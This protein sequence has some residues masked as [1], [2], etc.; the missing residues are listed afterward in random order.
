MK[1]AIYVRVSTEGQTYEQQITKCKQYCLIKDWTDVDIYSETESSTKVRPVWEEC[2]RQ[3]RKG[4]YQ[5]II[6]FRLDRAWRSARQFI[7][8]FDSL[9][10]HGISI[11]SVMEGLDPSTP[12]GKAMMTILVA[13]GELERTQISIATKQ[14]LNALKNEGKHLGRKFGSKDKIVRKVDGYKRRWAK[15]RGSKQYNVFIPI[16][17]KL[18]SDTE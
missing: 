4:K 8:D 12:M 18:K 17:E 16:N 11:I 15:T 9:Q 3:A 6:V 1:V 5:F 10:A 2:L 7:M 13:L 14:R